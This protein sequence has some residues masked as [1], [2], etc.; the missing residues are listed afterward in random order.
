MLQQF[1][2]AVT[3]NN[4]EV[5]GLSFGLLPPS[6]VEGG[7]GD[8]IDQWNNWTP[9]QGNQ[10]FNNGQNSGFSRSPAQNSENLQQA[11]GNQIP[12]TIADAQQFS[13]DARQNNGN[14]QFNLNAVQRTTNSGGQSFAANSN[15]QNNGNLNQPQTHQD[16][17]P[18]PWIVE[19]VG[20]VDDPAPLDTPNTQ[21]TVL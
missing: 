8:N 9:A 14:Q 18:V 15:F 17:V 12:Q 19:T 16:I 1:P 3:N 7:N 6:S 13:R 21:G 2:N 4:P 10:N 20:G 5:P 11:R